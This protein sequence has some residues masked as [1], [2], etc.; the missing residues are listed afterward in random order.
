MTA[1]ETILTAAA[2][3]A[4]PFSF[5]QL[6]LA[7]WRRNPEAFGLPD[8]REMYPDARKLQNA[9]YAKCGVILKKELLSTSVGFALPGWKVVFLHR[10][11][12]DA[13]ESKAFRAFGAGGKEAITFTEAVA[14]W[15]LPT[16]LVAGTVGD[17][18]KAFETLLDGRPTSELRV[19]GACHDYL[20]E[21]FARQIRLSD[22]KKS[23]KTTLGH[24]AERDAKESL[25]RLVG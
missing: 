12:K 17:G 24:K 22:G 8:F 21:R 15:G 6:L 18:V 13:N 10:A 9:L 16:T 20:V 5:G 14:F 19:L 4:G 2:E 23:D 25:Q 1:R 7:C 11:L 3:F